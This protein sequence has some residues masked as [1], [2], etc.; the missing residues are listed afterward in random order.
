MQDVQPHNNSE[1]CWVVIDRVVVDATLFLD[2]HPGG[3]DRILKLA[4]KDATETFALIGHSNAAKKLVAH[5]A[6]GTLGKAV[7]IKPDESELDIHGD[8]LR[9]WLV[10]N[11]HPVLARLFNSGHDYMH[12]HALMGGTVLASFA[13]RLV[14]AVGTGFTHFTMARPTILN[15]ATLAVHMALPLASLQFEVPAARKEW[16]IIHEGRRRE[17][18]LFS[19]KYASAAALRWFSPPGTQLLVKLAH[20]VAM[21]IIIDVSNHVF[22]LHYEANGTP[23]RGSQKVIWSDEQWSTWWNIFARS[24]HHFGPMFSQSLAVVTSLDMVSNRCDPSAVIDTMFWALLPIQGHAF[25]QTLLRKGVMEDNWLKFA[26]YGIM[27]LPG[28]ANMIL[29]GGWV[30]ILSTFTYMILRCQLPSTLFT[31]YMIY[32]IIISGVTLIRRRSAKAKGE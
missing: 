4:G 19:L 29:N 3:A 25:E 11:D 5:Y 32:V 1:S 30:S 8:W 13:W 2:K 18:I 12:V 17:T 24:I 16:N 20:V 10:K 27:L 28:T 9:T 6:V 26:L 14:V 22:D 31:K 15:V 23:V 7:V 21:H